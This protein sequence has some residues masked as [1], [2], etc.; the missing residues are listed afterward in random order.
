MGV[1]TRWVRPGANLPRGPNQNDRARQLNEGSMNTNER[2]S[3]SL[4]KHSCSGA[5]SW[6][7]AVSE[8]V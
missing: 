1:P 6:E 2:K 7:S 8:V 3:N 5:G 4:G